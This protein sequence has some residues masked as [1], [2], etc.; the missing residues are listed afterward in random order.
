MITLLL[1]TL[2]TPLVSKKETLISGG[3]IVTEFGILA[4]LYILYVVICIAYTIFILYQKSKTPDQKVKTQLNNLG[5]VIVTTLTIGLTTN[6]F[7]PFLFKIF[8]FQSN[9]PVISIFFTGYIFYSIVKH[10]FLDI[11]F[12]LGKLIFYSLLAT[13]PYLI[14]FCLASIYEL[15]FGTSINRVAFV[16]SIPISFCFVFFFNYFKDYLQNYTT[17]KLINPGYNPLEVSAKL[18]QEI[19]SILEIDKISNTALETIQKTIR[20]DYSGILVVTNNEPFTTKSFAYKDQPIIPGEDLHFIVDFWAN[21][22]LQ[23]LIYEELEYNLQDQ[24]R[25]APHLIQEIK[26]IMLDKGLRAFIPLIQKD[27]LAGMLLLGPKEADS[28]Y[29]K[30]DTDFLIQIANS[31]SLSLNR[32]MLYEQSLQFTHTLEK[33]VEEATNELKEKNGSLEQ[34]LIKLEEARRQ[35][36]DMIDVMGHELRTPLSIVRNALIVLNQDFQKDRMIETEKLERYLK[37][38]IESIRREVTLV[39]TLL[40]ATKFEGKRIQLQLSKVDF[41]DVVNDSI[42]A[43][44]YRA[45]EKNL[46]LIFTPPNQ[47]IFVYAD[48]VRTQEIMDNFLSNAIKYTAKGS[49]SINITTNEKFSRINVM[50]TGIGIA[51]DDLA[52][53]G[54]KFFRAKKIFGEKDLFVHPSGTG[55]GLYVT[56]QLIDVMGG[57]RI[58][59]SETGKGSTFAF[60]LPNYQDQ[61]EQMLDQT[62]MED[63]TL[64]EEAE[65]A[66]K[67]EI[68]DAVTKIHTEN[69]ANATQP[70]VEKIMAGVEA[71][72]ASDT[73]LAAPN[74]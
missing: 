65:K 32:A 23:P 47:E 54:K 69:L 30:Q 50:D 13:I 19:S 18:S 20:P 10:Q 5:W 42:E 39:E 64:H 57:K 36:R 56:F 25:Q 12:L 29:N 40:S 38:G 49:I 22:D 51:P 61:P 34:A 48:R 24:F 16:I 3:D 70:A 15:I 26:K 31:I 41:V 58:I 52:N 37:M 1:L 53:L 33:K 66:V 55:L 60:E 35:E 72:K 8:I 45:E 44:Q 28:Q 4:P 17:T 67:N 2:F 71:T 46:Q 27:K 7:L 9:S 63:K 21:L 14:F 62:F 68:A 74:L 43:H 73:Q 6:V 11:R 59:T